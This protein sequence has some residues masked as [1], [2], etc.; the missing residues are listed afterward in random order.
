MDCLPLRWVVEQ[1]LSSWRYGTAVAVS[2]LI[3]SN[4]CL[5]DYGSLRLRRGP[6]MGTSLLRAGD[7]TPRR[8]LFQ[9][10]RRLAVGQSAASFAAHPTARQWGIGYT[11]SDQDNRSKP[12]IRQYW[13]SG[14]MN[15]SQPT[16]GSVT[17]RW[18]S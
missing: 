18:M 16:G 2:D 4:C 10:M 1:P 12:C 6:W 15:S 13:H 5:S 3:R 7:Y 17:M 9:C 14:S 8:A 11:G